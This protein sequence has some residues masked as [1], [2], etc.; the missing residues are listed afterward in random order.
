VQAVVATAAAGDA[1]IAALASR[2]DA[3]RRVVA[4]WLVDGVHRRSGLRVERE[5]AVDTA[6]TLLDPVVHG[7]LT[8]DCGWSSDAFASWLADALARLLLPDP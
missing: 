5:R 7:R 2:I 1:E 3:Q 8:A 4:S 6:W